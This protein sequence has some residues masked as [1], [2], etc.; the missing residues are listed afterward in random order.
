M[1]DLVVIFRTN[2]EVE[3]SIVRGLLEANGIPSV[4]A[5]R[6]S[7]YPLAVTDLAEVRLSVREAGAAGGHRLSLPRSRAARARDDPHVARQRRHHRRRRRQRV[8]RIPG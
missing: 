6:V 5:S 4:A 7:Q 1:A 3:A 2:S 8:A